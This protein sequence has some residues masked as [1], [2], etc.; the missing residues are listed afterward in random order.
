M[1]NVVLKNRLEKLV[2]PKIPINVKDEQKLP[3][4]FNLFA[5]ATIIDVD[6]ETVHEYIV[7]GGGDKGLDG[8]Y[9]TEDDEVLFFQSKYFKNTEKQIGENE[10]N[11]ILLTIQ[12]IFTGKDILQANSLLLDKIK[13]IRILQDETPKPLN[14]KILFISN[15]EKT[16]TLS[17][18]AVNILKDKINKEEYKNISYLD[19]TAATLFAMLD[20]N[21]KTTE[22]TIT[23]IGDGSRY[24]IAGI[25]SFII[26]LKATE[27]M[28]LYEDCG[29]ENIFIDNVRYYLDKTQINDEI[30]KTIYDKVYSQYFFLFNNGISIIAENIESPDYFKSGI[31]RK[32]KIVKPSIING[33]QTT[34]TLYNVYVKNPE[35]LENISVLVKIYQT[36]TKD[37][38][39]KITIGTNSQNAITNIDLK[40]NNKIQRIIQDYFKI[41]NVGLE[42]KRGEFNNKKIDFTTTIRNDTLL[43]LYVSTFEKKPHS[44]RYKNKALEYFDKIFSEQ[45]KKLPI[46]MYRSYELYNYVITMENKTPINKLNK[47]TF[48]KY[49]TFSIMYIMTLLDKELLNINKNFNSFDC[50]DLYN[51]SVAILDKIVKR[52]AKENKEAYSNGLFFKSKNST[53]LI[54]NTIYNIKK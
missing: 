15:T 19:I 12:N 9:I 26:N 37:L 17:E 18:N 42:T 46:K 30:K 23:A 51:K 20:N 25:P 1:F 41:N 40:S 14:I 33:G 10:V 2:I 53:D 32:L 21:I 28:K 34:K 29:K 35:L 8:I 6:I 5:I 52:K 3:H 7:D 50:D 38:I 45:D 22:T 44:A 27:L 16:A 49:A 13:T 43:Q 47:Y 31:N 4:A 48:I 54:E 24:N 39:E 11:K 36:S